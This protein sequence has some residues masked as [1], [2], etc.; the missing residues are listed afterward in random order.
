MLSEVIHLLSLR[1]ERSLVAEFNFS[2]YLNPGSAQSVVY[3]VVGGCNLMFDG[4]IP[5]H[6][7]C[8]VSHGNQRVFSRHRRHGDAAP[9]SAGFLVDGIFL[10]AGLSDAQITSQAPA[11]GT[12][13]GHR[14]ANPHGNC[15]GKG[16]T[17]DIWG[18]LLASEIRVRSRHCRWWNR[19]CCR[20]I[21]KY[22]IRIARILK[23]S[24]S[25]EIFSNL[26]F[27]NPISGDLMFPELNFSD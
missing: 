17:S 16:R 13:R 1:Y 10:G 25:L 7:F 8:W 24:P 11:S 4:A 27:P 2:R 18:E 21:G 15:S 5:S 6:R 23:K 3:L 20:S 14:S 19:N 12:A 26:S 22:I 9:R